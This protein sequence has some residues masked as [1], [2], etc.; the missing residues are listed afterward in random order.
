MA[1]RLEQ[2]WKGDRF[3]ILDPAHLPEKPDSPRPLPILA[4]GMVLGLLA[5]LGAAAAR[6]AFDG[7]VKDAEQLAK[8]VPCPVV[9]QLSPLAVKR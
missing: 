7:T 1:G 2:R 3:R 5:G 6:E 9:G 8:L 4:L